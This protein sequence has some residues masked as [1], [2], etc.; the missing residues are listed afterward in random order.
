V[1][2]QVHSAA[3]LAKGEAT[4]GSTKTAKASQSGWKEGEKRCWYESKRGRYLLGE[5]VLGVIAA[6][7]GPPRKGIKGRKR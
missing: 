1:P 3:R 4:K 7:E 5:I 6:A 2:S